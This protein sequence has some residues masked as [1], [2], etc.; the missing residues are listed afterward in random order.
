[1]FNKRFVSAVVIC[2]AIGLT[3]QQI[4]PPATTEKKKVCSTST[5]DSSGTV[6]TWLKGQA[7]EL[8]ENSAVE[9]DSK[10]C[11][12]DFDV[13]GTCCK[14]ASVKT[15]I[16]KQNDAMV[17]K[18]KAYIAAL[19]PIKNKMAAALK[20]LANKMSFKDLENK[21]NLL[22]NGASTFRAALKMLP[23]SI[24]QI[25]TLKTFLQDFDSN[26]ISTFKAQAGKCY[27]S[28]KTARANYICALCSTN[29]DVY[30]KSAST[31]GSS[32]KIRFKT[33]IE[34][35]RAIVD[36]C[37][38]IWRFNWLLTTSIQYVLVLR[39]KG[40]G[41]NAVNPLKNSLELTD[42]V[43]TNLAATFQAC[44]IDK[45][46][47][48]LTCTGT[49]TSTD[50]HNKRLCSDALAFNKE[51]GAIEGDGSLGSV[52][53]NDVGKAADEDAEGDKVKDEVAVRLL[54]TIS[55]PPVDSVVGADIEPT[56]GYPLSST[57]TGVVPTTSPDA[58]M[59]GDAAPSSA[60]KIAA[61]L[62]GIFVSLVVIA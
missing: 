9:K 13:Y 14:G 62:F 21:K 40:K 44:S 2:L 7:I 54:Q 24:A 25:S 47:G 6:L 38:P 51:N 29:S 10:I 56:G 33:S 34:A 5:V 30:V 27:D 59:A 18:W 32:T 11:V 23:A 52:D 37:Y 1:M 50:D 35:C 53:P 42:D 55:T 16:N 4:L 22:G 43:L 31:S 46:T 57:D 15:Y 12:K 45:T 61:S 36:A 41:E 39:N 48:K 60:F 17:A 20:R 58:T 3:L 8:Y 19:A 28:L 26:G 49:T